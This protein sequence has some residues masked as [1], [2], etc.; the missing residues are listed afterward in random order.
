M[1]KKLKVVDK[2]VLRIVDS[3]VVDHYDWREYWA[4]MA[5]VLTKLREGSR[6]NA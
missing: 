5:D 3:Y 2:T 4:K 1:S 6:G